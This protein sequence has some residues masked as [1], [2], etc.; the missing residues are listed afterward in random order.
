M[1]NSIEAVGSDLRF[2]ANIGSPS[3]LIAGMTIS[4]G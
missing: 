3:I 1:L 4:G 2:I